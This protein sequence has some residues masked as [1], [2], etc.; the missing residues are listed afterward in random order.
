MQAESCGQS[1]FD[2]CERELR[3]S[4]DWQRPPRNQRR[5]GATGKRDPGVLQRANPPPVE[6]A[7]ALLEVDWRHFRGEVSAREPAASANALP[8]PGL[9]PRRT[10]R[11]PQPQR[12]MSDSERSN[13]KSAHPATQR[14]WG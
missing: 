12:R 7:R 1:Q 9:G 8:C 6:W 11:E 3:P 4:G 14:K 2:H 10:D 13:A 5:F